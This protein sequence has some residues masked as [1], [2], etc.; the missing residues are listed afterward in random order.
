MN[1]TLTLWHTP[2]CSKSRAALALLEDA[3]RAPDVRLYLQTPPSEAELTALLGKLSLS[4][5]DLI[6]RGE[7]L[8]RDLSLKDADDAALIVAMAT[9]PILIERPILITESA[10]VIGRPTEAIAALL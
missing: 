6:R 10:A 5:R 1:N 8:Y 7:K 2:R 9:H 3:G 4:P